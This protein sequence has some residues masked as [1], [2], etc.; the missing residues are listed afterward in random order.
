MRYSHF[1]ALAL[2]MSNG[3]GGATAAD[4]LTLPAS[5]PVSAYFAPTAEGSPPATESAF[6]SASKSAAAKSL[7]RQSVVVL[8]DDDSLIVIPVGLKNRAN[9]AARFLRQTTFGANRTAIERLITQGYPAWIEEQFAKPAVSHLATVMADP[10]RTTSPWDVLMPSIW[11]QYFEGDDQLRQRVS[12]ALSQIFVVSLSNNTLNDAPC[13]T[14]AYLDILNRNAFGSAR[15]LLKEI[16]L[17]AAMGEY[18]SMKESA[19]ADPLLQTQ[20]DENY[21]RELLQLFSIGTVM[22]NN[23]G[24]AKRDAGNNTIATYTEDTVKE[25]AKA[26]SG[27]SFA[28]QDQQNP[29]RWLNPDLWD[30]DPLI[31]AKKSCTA[32][33]TPMEPWTEVFK[34]VDNKRYI[35]GPAH[36]T[37][38]KQLLSYPDAPHPSLPAYLQPQGLLEYVQGSLEKLLDNVFY[39]PNVGPFLAKQLIQ[40][41]VTSNPSPAYVDRVAQKFNDNGGGVRGDM[42]AVIRAILLDN[43]A[44][45]SAL[46]RQPTY[47]KLSEPVVRFVQMHRAFNATRPNGYRG[48]WDFSAPTSLNQNP[49]RAPSV[50]NFYPPD[51]SPA[52]PLAKNG[53]VGPE[54]GITNSTSVAG[55]ADFSKWGI[56]GGFDHGSSTAGNRMIPDYSFY[57]A[58]TTT[59]RDLID[60]LDLL[61]CAGGLNAT[62]K[63]QLVQSVSKVSVSNPVTAAQ[64]AERLNMAL[65]L[66]INS[67]DY[68][69]Q[70]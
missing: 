33:S 34:S 21:A 8:L 11:K 65:W 44:R 58:L 51:Y 30:A 10:V 5:L 59:P 29:S 61:L 27:W 66:I 20:P 14:A 57:L 4:E 3:V 13:G 24:T 54:F 41:L 38:P 25:F 31:R 36:D 17:S 18:L 32:W 49:L 53:L 35:S 15:T 40:R 23:D 69:V 26:L 56:I 28:G 62:F 68:S 43:E 12:F 55:F 6:Q 1:F 67:P 63:A 39:H 42:K 16:T 47:G 19:K 7:T 46:A 50:F 48:L 22:L 45:N 37:G 2:T 9:A 64:R 60:E 70:K 52:G